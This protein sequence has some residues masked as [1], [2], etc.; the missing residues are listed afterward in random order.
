MTWW[1][2]FIEILSWALILGGA[3]FTLVGAFGLVRLPDFWPR[4]HAASVSESAGMLLLVTGM[5]IQAGFGL[6]AVKLI[7]IALFLFITGPT[8]TH[9]VANAG[10]VSGL[11]PKSD[12]DGTA[13]TTPDP[14][15]EP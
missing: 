7:I 5:A 8:S 6:I 10:L 11:R 13:G 9:A 12:V 4:L 1:G 15:D 2:L 14:E 3:G